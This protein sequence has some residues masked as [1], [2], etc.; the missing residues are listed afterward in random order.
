MKFFILLLFFC[1]SCLKGNRIT[2]NSSE[3][4]NL[5][6]FNSSKNVD[7]CLVNVLKNSETG[8]C[9]LNPRKKSFCNEFYPENE[10]SISPKENKEILFKGLSNMELNE[11]FKKEK[12]N[13]VNYYSTDYFNSV[14]KVDL[15][16]IHSEIEK[17]LKEE[18]YKG[19]TKTLTP[20]MEIKY[21]VETFS[22]KFND[23]AYANFSSESISFVSSTEK[24]L[25][26]LK[27]ILYKFGIESF[28]KEFSK[29]KESFK[30]CRQPISGFFKLD[31]SSFL[32]CK[33]SI[34]KLFPKYFKDIE[35][36]RI[37]N[38]A[39]L[40]S[41]DFE[42]YLPKENRLNIGTLFK[43]GQKYCKLTIDEILNLGIRKK[44]AYNL[45]YAISFH[46]AI[47]DAM[48]INKIFIEKR[49]SYF[50][51]ISSSCN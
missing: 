32:N 40:T 2:E 37:G 41:Y 39:V 14:N 36:L 51:E 45:C 46:A 6:I 7:F 38:E 10:F 15:G 42:Y 34:T 11:N 8:K 4:L 50:K 33:D 12:L 20:E 28:L 3:F 31:Q 18:S 30:S 16:K 29:D 17:G 24:D 5:Y 1:N 44:E 21:I 47:L 13:Y 27:P 22:P 19:S 35:T 49:E 48:N 9:F 23:V 26:K 25:T 43:I